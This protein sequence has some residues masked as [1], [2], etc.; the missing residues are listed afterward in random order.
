MTIPLIWFTISVIM[1]RV[2]PPVSRGPQMV[3]RV[4]VLLAAALAI[5]LIA[6]TIYAFARSPDADPVFRLGKSAPA[7]QAGGTAHDDVRVFTGIGRLRIPLSNSS[8][9]ILSIAF[10]YAPDDRAFSE[11][12]AARIGDFRAA[13]SDYFSSLPA[14][15]LIHIDEAAAKTEIL[16]RYNTR[17]R[18]GRIEALY[19]SDMLV[20]D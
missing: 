13:A 2:L 14:E 9:L 8:T 6:G 7:G 16:R 1:K 17:L 15:E 12:L 18:L 20:I 3:F 11:E 10:P 5:L 4:M 19:F